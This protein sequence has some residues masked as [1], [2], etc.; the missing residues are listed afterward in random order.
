MIDIKNI[1]EDSIKVL[2]GVASAIAVAN[3][4]RALYSRYALKCFDR[5]RRW[6][7][8]FLLRLPRRHKRPEFVKVGQASKLSKGWLRSLM[9]RLPGREKGPEFVKVGQASK[10]PKG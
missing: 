5:M 4:L 9:L 3:V 10:S 7:R 6:W 1:V 8:A 2:G